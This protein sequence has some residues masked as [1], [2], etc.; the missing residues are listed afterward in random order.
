MAKITLEFDSVEELEEAKYAI[1]GVKWY[2]VLTEVDQH[3]RNIV[4]YSGAH[5]E[6]EI[7]FA[8]SIREKI[9]EI[10]F[11]KNLFYD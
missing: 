4:K 7:A 2:S 6:E 11:D 1:E 8:E 3:L 5:S 9:R 10:A